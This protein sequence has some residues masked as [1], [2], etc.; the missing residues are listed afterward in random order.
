MTTV[1]EQLA[2][3]AGIADGEGCFYLTATHDRTGRKVVKYSFSV[4]NTNKLIILEVKR[5][6]ESLFGHEVR[7]TPI[8]GRGNRKSSWLIQATSLGDLQTLCNALMPFLIGKRDQA[9]TMLEFIAIGHADRHGRWSG[10]DRE[11]YEKRLAL[12]SKM[13]HLNRFRTGDSVEL[14]PQRETE[15]PAPMMDEETV[16]TASRGAEAQETGARR[17]H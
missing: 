11:V 13:K 2:W 12:V 14:L 15:R 6:F 16:R 4:G 1:N 17:V 3:L 9:L 10:P 8:K 7:Y 5:I